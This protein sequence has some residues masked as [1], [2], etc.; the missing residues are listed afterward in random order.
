MKYVRLILMR[1][2]ETPWLC[3]GHEL[4]F[5]YEQELDQVLAVSCWF[6]HKKL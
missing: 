4:L 1:C 5:D 3:F 2:T 6:V